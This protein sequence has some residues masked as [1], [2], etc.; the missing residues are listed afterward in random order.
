VSVKRDQVAHARPGT[1][2]VGSPPRFRVLRPYRRQRGAK[3]T[4]PGQE[5]THRRCESH[6]STPTGDGDRGTKKTLRKCRDRVAAGTTGSRT[7]CHD[8]KEGG[9]IHRSFCCRAGDGKVFVG[10]WRPTFGRIEVDGDKWARG[11]WRGCA[12][13]FAMFADGPDGAMWLANDSSSVSDYPHH[14]ENERDS[15]APTQHRRQGAALAERMSRAIVRKAN[16]CGRTSQK[17][18]RHSPRHEASHPAAYETIKPM[19]PLHGA[20]VGVAARSRCAFRAV[21]CFRRAAVEATTHR[22][23]PPRRAAPGCNAFLWHLD[24]QAKGL[25]AASVRR[26]LGGGAE[27]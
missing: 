21:P 19:G 2:R 12:N 25:F 11:R 27:R 15:C 14:A 10:G 8:R 20:K 16:N 17:A 4:K 7:G 9:F 6:C 22:R 23:P 13:A 3:G 5:V 18:R 26:R 1:L 24:R